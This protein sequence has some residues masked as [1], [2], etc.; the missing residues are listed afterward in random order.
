MGNNRVFFGT[1]PHVCVVYTEVLKSFA[2]V[3]DES[4]TLF[5]P[6]LLIYFDVFRP[7]PPA[8][9]P[10]HP[11]VSCLF[12]SSCRWFLLCRV[13]SQLCKAFTCCMLGNVSALMCLSIK[14]CLLP[15]LCSYHTVTQREL[16]YRLVFTCVFRLA[17]VL[18]P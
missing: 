7:R 8:C 17:C 1:G 3:C 18:P 2:W 6:D 13:R 4:V 10:P 11:S 12:F 16:G 5:L 14:E 15:D 9:S